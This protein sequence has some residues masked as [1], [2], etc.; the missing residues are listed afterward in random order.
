[1]RHQLCLCTFFSL[2]GS[3][4]CLGQIT[5]NIRADVTPAPPV[6]GVRL[7][8]TNQGKEEA[9]DIQVNLRDATD[10]TLPGRSVLASGGA[11]DTTADLNIAGK[12]PGR[13]PLFVT[14][15]YSDQNGYQFS[16]ILCATFFIEQDTSSEIFGALKTSP[17]ADSEHVQLQ[18][19]NLAR[20]DRSFNMTIFSP[21]ELS[22]EYDKKLSLK[23]AEEKKVRIL[24]RNFSAL[25]GSRYPIYAVAEYEKDGRHFTNVILAYVDTVAQT[26][27]FTRH[28]TWILT[29]AAAFL[30]LGILLAALRFFRQALRK[31]TA[32][33]Q[34]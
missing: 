32:L 18:L 34:E 20:Q 10:V 30:V 33:R 27:F 3:T 8:I 12:A 28:R 11:F 7:V 17:L 9:H 22:A 19:K 21:R 14:V 15:G 26:A 29:A 23:P 31:K 25:P 2:L 4:L 1:M 16:A 6:L 24:L 5:L 13:Y